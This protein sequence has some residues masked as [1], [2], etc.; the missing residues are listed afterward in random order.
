MNCGSSTRNIL[1]M[2]YANL[3]WEAARR[4]QAKRIPDER[5]DVHKEKLMKMRDYLPLDGIMGIM[6]RRYGFEAT[7]VISCWLVG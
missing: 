2:P 1:T 4:P 7:Y 6:A 5:W 3:R